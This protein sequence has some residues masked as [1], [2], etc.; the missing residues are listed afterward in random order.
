[1]RDSYVG[2]FRKYALLNTLAGND[3][4]YAVWARARCLVLLLRIARVVFLNLKAKESVNGIDGR[5]IP[6]RDDDTSSVRCFLE[7]VVNPLL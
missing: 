5:F 2:D 3:L 6:C 7:R 4:R 1:M